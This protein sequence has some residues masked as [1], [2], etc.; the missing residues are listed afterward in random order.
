MQAHFG[1]LDTM[2]GFADTDVAATQLSATLDAAGND[3]LF[4]YTYPGVGHA[5]MNADPVIMTV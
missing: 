1:E 3:R 4:L 5:F 2:V